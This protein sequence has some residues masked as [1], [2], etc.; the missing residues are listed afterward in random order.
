LILFF[1]SCDSQGQQTRVSTITETWDYQD[2]IMYT[3]G[4]EMNKILIDH[5]I[6]VKEITVK[7]KFSDKENPFSNNKNVFTFNFINDSVLIQKGME[8]Y[9]GV[10]RKNEILIYDSITKKAQNFGRCIKRDSAGYILEHKRCFNNVDTSDYYYTEKID[11]QGRTL[12]TSF[13]IHAN[14]HALYRYSY[15]GDSITHFC[16][17][18]LINNDTLLMNDELTLKTS[19]REKN[20]WIRESKYTSFDYKENNQTIKSSGI[21]SSKSKFIYDKLNRIIKVEIYT[22]KTTPETVLEIE[23]K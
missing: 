1:S 14:Y 12:E 11:E 4:E 23:Y 5:P 6:G 13:F 18:R 19:I 8:G 21:S 17:Y 3:C 16:E 2:E 22:G 9:Y 15:Q 7:E 10:I 20:T